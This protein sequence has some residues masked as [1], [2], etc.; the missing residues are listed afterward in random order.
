VIVLPENRGK[1]AAVRAGVLAARGR[2]V[3]YLDADLAYSPDQLLAL[4]EVVEAG[5]ELVT[6]SRR[7]VGTV[8]VVRAG[9][10]RELTGRA[11]NRLSQI[12]LL[13][14][15][16]DTQCGIKAMRS[17]SA[18]L[19]FSRSRVDGFAFEI[20]VFHL[21][22]RYGLSLA[23]VPVTV[24]NSSQSTVRVVRHGLEMVRDLLRIRRLAGRGAYDRAASPAAGEPSAAGNLGRG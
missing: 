1:G 5:Y 23:E 17:D 7:H 15:Y 8:T 19:V 9:R 24:T 13:G 18:R 4:L 3:A 20:E 21:A 11:F 6:G 10:L 16:R 22:E 2:T 12:V 14:H